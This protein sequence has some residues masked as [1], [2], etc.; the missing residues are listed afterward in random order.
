M[1]DDTVG[2][3]IWNVSYMSI[4]PDNPDL[5][6]IGLGDTRKSDCTCLRMPIE[7]ARSLAVTILCTTTPD[8]RDEAKAA[9]RANAATRD[10]A[11]AA[12]ASYAATPF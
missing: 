7:E 9:Y 4:D 11:K 6:I 2:T 3:E 10:E 12:L 1:I 5:V 8:D